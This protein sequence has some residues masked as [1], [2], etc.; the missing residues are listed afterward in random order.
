MVVERAKNRGKAT[1]WACQC[2]CGVQ[3]VF[4]AGNLRSGASSSC[5]CLQIELTISRSTKHGCSPRNQRTP[6][7][8][9]WKH[10]T[11]RTTNPKAIR[12]ADYGGRGVTLCDRWANNFENF[13]E[14]MGLKPS[15]KHSIERKDNDLGYSPE[16]CYWATAKEQSRNT[17]KNRFVT[18]KGATKCVGEWSEILGINYGTLLSRLNSPKLSITQVFETPIGGIC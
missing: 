17:R 10:V 1:T 4:S 11:Q 15:P 12:Y 2:D 14:D 5:G 8:R 13:L 9:T 3:K 16:N 6:E 18:Y 7:Y